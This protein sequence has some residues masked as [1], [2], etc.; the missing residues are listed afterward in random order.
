MRHAFKKRIGPKFKRAAVASSGTADSNARLPHWDLTELYPGLQSKQF[1]EDKDAFKK[2]CLAF[3]EA[4]E[5]RIKYLDAEELEGAIR[6]YEEIETAYRKMDRYLVLLEAQ[7]VSNLS[8]TSDVHKEID[9]LQEEVTFFEREV[10]GVAEKDAILQSNVYNPWLAYVRATHKHD[11]PDANDPDVTTAEDIC[12]DLS[13]SNMSGWTRLYREAYAA[14]R[15]TTDAGDKTLD[16]L[17]DTLT[18]PAVSFDDKKKNRQLLGQAVKEHAPKMAFIYSRIVKD[19]L[20][21]DAIRGYGRPDLALHIE[22][23][24]EPEVVDTMM[25][26]V[27]S[28]YTRLSHRFYNW[29]AEQFG[30]R[31]LERAHIGETM[32]G[33]AEQKAAKYTFK[34]AKD[35]ILKSFRS[36]SQAFATAAARMFNEN[37]IDAQPR[38]DK[39]TGCYSISI[40]PEIRPYIMS[41]FAGDVGSIVTLGH[42][43]GHSIQD[44]R[45]FAT[46][47]VL[48]A[49]GSTALSETASV[50]AEQIVFDEMLKREKNPVL[51][52]NLL[53]EKVDGLLQTSL[54]QAACHDFETK[55][56]EQ[57]KKK[58]LNAEEI[59]DIWLDTK[60]A[61]YG[62]VVQTDD[63]ERYYWT[64][65][66]HFFNTPFYVH[67]Y[68]MAQLSV[69]ALWEKYEEARDRGPDDKKEFVDNYLE[70]L[71]TGISKNMYQQF[72]PFNLDPETPEFWQIG[73]KQIERY[74]DQLEALDVSSAPT[75]AAS[76]KKQA[77][78]KHKPKK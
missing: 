77:A 69:S 28:S 43:L 29:K 21:E 17:H 52:R 50:F 16:E 57:M 40:T 55:V 60:K 76:D 75:A 72:R 67:A 18:D 7:K 62:H 49:D 37:R 38:P 4:Y 2:S 5:D 70:L 68:C 19:N 48:M 23:M 54:L 34:Q 71:Q 35:I 13:N 56:H 74:M 6:E 1:K 11:L 53:M 51:K 42:E 30:V 63:Y 39:E 32:P 25:D 46:Q 65:I 20:T 24:V 64:V 27:R 66:P 14:I 3:K 61:Y 26:V 47:G 58:D 44:M 33:V 31:K 9:K 41:D 78:A 73:L 22:N 12:G 8:K 15:V 10:A 59:S 36:F 45:A